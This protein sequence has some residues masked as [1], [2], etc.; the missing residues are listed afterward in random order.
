MEQNSASGQWYAVCRLN[1]LTKFAV[2]SAERKMAA[3]VIKLAID[4]LDVEVG[5]QI[6]TLDAP[7]YIDPIT[8]RTMVPLRL[9]SES[10]GMD[11]KWEASTGHIFITG[12]DDEITLQIGSRGITVNGTGRTMDTVPVTMPPGRT[13]VPLRFVSEALGAQVDYNSTT[14][15]IIIIK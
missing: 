2:F 5:G 7:P 4:C 3:K 15:S 9:I 10:M 12:G 6:L 14:K 13:L 1:H 8:A 11:V